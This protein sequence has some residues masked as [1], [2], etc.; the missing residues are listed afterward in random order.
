MSTGGGPGR[1]C[2]HRARDPPEPA[3]VRALDGLVTV[4]C[5][6]PWTQPWPC[7]LSLQTILFPKMLVITL[8]IFDFQGS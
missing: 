6:W 1:V 2:A 5:L 4:G 8:L 3:V 7:L